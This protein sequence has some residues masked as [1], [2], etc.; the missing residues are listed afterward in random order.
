MKPEPRATPAT[1]A[2]HTQDPSPN[3]LR[4]A[5]A[6]IRPS[7]TAT[8]AAMRATRPAAARTPPEWPSRAIWRITQCWMGKVSRAAENAQKTQTMAT[9]ANP[10]A[11]RARV[12]RAMKP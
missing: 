9:G 4:P 1:A 5:T 8:A 12:P 10:S 7:P 2:G 6:A 3:S 11:P